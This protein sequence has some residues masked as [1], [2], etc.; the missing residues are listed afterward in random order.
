MTKQL[1]AS[2]AISAE[3]DDMRQMVGALEL[4]RSC[5]ACSLS[6]AATLP[7]PLRTRSGLARP[8]MMSTCYDVALRDELGVVGDRAARAALEEGGGH[9]RDVPGQHRAADDH[10]LVAPAQLADVLEHA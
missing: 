3:A 6:P 8:A 5:T 9:L 10:V 1:S 4:A 2:F 7:S